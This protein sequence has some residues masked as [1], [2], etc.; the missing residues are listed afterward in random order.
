MV[1]QAAVSELL[2]QLPVVS[3]A[4]MGAALAAAAAGDQGNAL[5]LA[6]QA[7]ARGAV[8]GLAALK[9]DV[10]SDGV[11][12]NMDDLLLAELQLHL[13]NIAPVLMARM[14]GDSVPGGARAKRNLSEHAFLG[15]G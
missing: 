11:A 12:T 5:Q 14:K 10:P 6:I 2:L 1:K 8:Q 3:Q 15:L 4:A 7:A 9:P 13:Q